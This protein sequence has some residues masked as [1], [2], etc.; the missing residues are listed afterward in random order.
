MKSNVARLQKDST[1]IGVGQDDKNCL[2]IFLTRQLRAMKKYQ[3]LVSKEEK[4][5]YYKKL[6]ND[7]KFVDSVKHQASRV[8][9]A[10]VVLEVGTG[11]I[12]SMVGGTDTVRGF[13]LNHVLDQKA[14]GF[15]V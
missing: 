5:D 10:F 2:M 1:A 13:G 12:L 8:Q 7:K 11:H 9:A 15:F 4:Q 14:A 6:K 3:I